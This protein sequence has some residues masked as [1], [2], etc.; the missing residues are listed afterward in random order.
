MHYFQAH[1]HAAVHLNDYLYP[2][3]FDWNGVFI[4]RSAAARSN[5]VY[6]KEGQV[7]LILGILFS[8]RSFVYKLSLLNRN[9]VLFD[10]SNFLLQTLLWTIFTRTQVVRNIDLEVEP[11]DMLHCIL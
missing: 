4:V 10:F 9:K 1:I 6:L 7:Q 2:H 8:I 11:S 5:Q 3:L